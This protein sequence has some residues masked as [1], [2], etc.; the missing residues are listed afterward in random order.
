MKDRDPFHK[1]YEEEL[2]AFPN[3]GP[4]YR[5][6]NF[7]TLTLDPPDIYRPN[8]QGL[9][10]KE[11]DKLILTYE[12]LDLEFSYENYRRYRVQESALF[13]LLGYMRRIE[14]RFRINELNEEL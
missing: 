11:R 7:I 10:R 4:A 6:V 5:H 12:L 1:E 2:R 14:R 13:F 8:L 9:Y 3:F